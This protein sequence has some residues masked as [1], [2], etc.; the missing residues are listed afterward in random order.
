LKEAKL[1]YREEYVIATTSDIAN[2]QVRLEK[3][4][5]IPTSEAKKMLL[6]FGIRRKR[7]SGML[8][9]Q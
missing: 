8:E 5:K 1:G 9:N 7:N 6:N 4:I 2:Y 3:L